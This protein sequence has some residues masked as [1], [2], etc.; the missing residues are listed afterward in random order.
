MPLLTDIGNLYTCAPHGAQ[1][2][3]HPI[4]DAALAWEGETVQ[5]VGAAAELPP[6]YLGWERRS[7]AGNMVIPGLVDC[8]THLAFGGLA[9]RRVR[10]AHPAAGAIWRSP[11][12]AA[13]SPRRCRRPGQPHRPTCSGV[14]RRTSAAMAR[15]GVTDNRGQE[16]LRALPRTGAPPPAGVCRTWDCAPSSASSPRC[17]AA[18]VVPAEFRDRRGAYLEMVIEELLPQ[19]AARRLARFCDVFVEEGAFTVG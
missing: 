11:P 17:S 10:S 19:V 4:R 14:A 6:R 16:R 15:L 8:H 1:G 5:W 9:R 7:A 2:Q 3:V 12:L 13:A 18:H